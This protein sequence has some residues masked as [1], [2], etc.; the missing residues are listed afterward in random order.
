MPDA[1]PTSSISIFCAAAPS[2]AML[3]AQWETHL[4][5]LQQ[6]GLLTVWSELH[7]AAGASRMEQL[8]EHLDQAQ[9]IVF[10]LSSDFFASDTC[11]ALVERALAGEA[12]V[13]ALLL[14][15]VDWQTSKLSNL[16]CL[17]ADGSF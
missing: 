7:L 1:K 13:I 10:L 12:R 15:P 14:R 4:L 3:L 8:A 16:A 5:P 2:D 6:R 17:P 11:M 9:V